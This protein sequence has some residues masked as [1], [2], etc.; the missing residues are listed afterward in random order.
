MSEADPD[1]VEINRLFARAAEAFGVPKPD[2][3]PTF[4]WANSV[5]NPRVDE[6]PTD[7]A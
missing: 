2:D 5:A 1:A 6:D 4:Y 7:R 3:L